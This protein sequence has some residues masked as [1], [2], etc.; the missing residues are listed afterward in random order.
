MFLMY[1]DTSQSAAAAALALASAIRPDLEAA[2]RRFSWQGAAI[3]FAALDDRKAGARLLE[4]RSLA[5][6]QRLLVEMEAE[7]RSET[8]EGLICVPV[9]YIDGWRRSDR[10][11]SRK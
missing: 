7:V 3:D 9:R 10:S 5:A 6:L 2:S 11:R 8:A 1:H 4:S